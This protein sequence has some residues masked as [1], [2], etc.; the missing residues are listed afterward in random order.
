MKKLVV[1]SASRRTDLVGCFPDA[2]IERLQ[3]YPLEQ[4]HSL[5]L[6]T[7]NPLPL[8]HNKHLRNQISPYRQIV[9]HLTVTGMG[10][11]IFEP[12]IPTSGQILKELPDI[13]QFAG[14]PERLVWRF[15]PI[16]HLKKGSQKY[17]NISFF[18][19]LAEEFSKHHISTIK[20]SWLSLYKKVIR[21]INKIGWEPA[22]IS[23]E[24]KKKQARKLECIA[25]K[26]NQKIE[27]C[28]ID[29]FPVSQCIDGALLNALH[30]DK[31]V[32]STKR[33]RG[34]RALCGCT[35]SIDIG[36]YNQACPH[37]CIYCYANPKID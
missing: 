4:V 23:L 28:C 30:P 8:I 36:W 5:V 12:H 37:G 16:M 21:N 22:D 10:G 29:G 1:I 6:W 26:N 25:Q 2:C 18:P 17:S 35:E 31:L 7:K 33:A 27:Y 32:C 15:D 13:I 34:Q 19:F 24:T 3:K 14:S 20:I 11:S 9:I